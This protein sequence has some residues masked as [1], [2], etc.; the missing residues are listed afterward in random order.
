SGGFSRYP[1]NGVVYGGMGANVTGVGQIRDPFL[2]RRFREE[3]SDLA[4]FDQSTAI[5]DDIEGSLDEV[6]GSGLQNALNKLN[7]ALSNFSSNPDQATHAN[8]VLTT[9]KNLVLNLKQY[10]AKLDD[11]A[12][13]QKYDL[14]VSVDSLNSSLSKIAALNKTIK[15]ETATIKEYQTGAYGPNELMDER[16]LLL[17]KISKYGDLNVQPNEDGTVTV[18]LNGKEVVKDDKF[19]QARLTTS[20]DSGDVS[21]K[22]A[23]DGKE[24]VLDNGSLKAYVDMI[25]GAGFAAKGKAA[26]FTKGIP[27]YKQGLDRIAGALVK[28]F[29]NS[30][31]DCHTEG[32]HVHDDKT[33]KEFKELLT[34]KVDGN[35]TAAGLEVSKE[36]VDNI[37]FIIPPPCVVDGA[38]NNAHI[39]ELK[40]ALT[41][42][43]DFNEFK[44]GV[45]E[46]INFYNGTIG[47][48]KS[49]YQ[50]RLVTAASVV[51]NLNDTKDSVSGV[52]MDEEG[53]NLM[54][55]DKAYKALGRLMT[56]MDEALDMIINRMGTVGR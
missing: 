45:S 2:D 55:Y 49:Y 24:M 35:P 30:I 25:N 22:W 4:Y 34:Y 37:S 42:D 29:N 18:K 20:K 50:N 7:E 44:G 54:L 32:E 3:N 52:N 9:T 23:S 13:Q 53:A 15:D 21:L 31:P 38:K 47:Q 28:A 36:W 1:V 12:N 11:V 33:P 43:F 39:L 46:Y 48:E 51:T 27:Y 40:D 26:N 8:I 14:Q 10:S 19:E 41:R 5:M 16:N 6:A 17:D 56:T